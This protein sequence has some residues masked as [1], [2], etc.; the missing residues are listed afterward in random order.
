MAK[1]DKEWMLSLRKL[2]PLTYNLKFLFSE[3]LKI[4]QIY[5]QSKNKGSQEEEHFI[6]AVG[7]AIFVGWF[8]FEYIIRFI[9]APQKWK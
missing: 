8:T 2:F 5:F 3:F 6:F 7:E 4:V 9:A 1:W